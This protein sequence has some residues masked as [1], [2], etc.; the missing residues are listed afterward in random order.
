MPCRQAWR[1]G[2]YGKHFPKN[3][4]WPSKF[5]LQS[6]KGQNSNLPF[7]WSHFLKINCSNI[8]HNLSEASEEKLTHDLFAFVSQIK[9]LTKLSAYEAKIYDETFK[10]LAKTWLHDPGASKTN[11]GWFLGRILRINRLRV[12]LLNI[13]ARNFGNLRKTS[14]LPSNILNS[15]SICINL[16]AERALNPNS[17]AFR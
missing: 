10:R 3:I 5:R 9:I 2:T 16:K 13:S 17:F 15:S 4:L 6:K 14:L 12:Q 11:F 8:F 1:W 7:Y